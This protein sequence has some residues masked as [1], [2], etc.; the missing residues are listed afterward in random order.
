MTSALING[1]AYSDDGTSGRDMTNGGHRSWLLPMLSDAMSECAGAASAASAASAA[2]ASALSAAAGW[3]GASDGTATVGSGSV[4]LTIEPGRQFRIGTP[5]L[6]YVTAVPGIRMAGIVSAY[7]IVTGALSVDVQVSEGTGTHA[8]WTVVVTGLRGEDGPIGGVE[9]L[10]K[11]AAYTMMAGDRG[12]VVRCS[13]SWALSFQ[14]AAALG[15]GWWAH[16]VNDGTGPIVLDPAGSELIDGDATLSV[17][18]GSYAMVGCDGTGLTVLLSGMHGVRPLPIF[19]AAAAGVEPFTNGE[20][21]YSGLGVTGMTSFAVFAAGTSLVI[22]ADTN[23]ARNTVASSADGLTWIY[24]MMPSVEQWAVVPVGSGFLGVSRSSVKTAWSTDGVSWS[25]R[26]DLAGVPS[27]LDTSG[28]QIAAVG[29]VALLCRSG[30]TGARTANGGVSWAD[31]TL[32]VSVP[33]LMSCGGLFVAH[34]PGSGAYY[35]S[36]TG[37]TG[38]WTVHTLPG[39]TTH[40]TCLP[41]GSVYAW[42][43]SNGSVA[44]YVSD[45]ALIWVATGFEGPALRVGPTWMSI[46]VGY[47]ATRT[48]HAGKWAVRTLHKTLPT[49][50]PG[51]RRFAQLGNRVLILDDAGAC[52]VLD[53]DDGAVSAV[54]RG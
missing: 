22:A 27:A 1:H 11:T 47:G 34:A 26:A 51:A 52:V 42:A 40:C 25:A 53:P 44:S 35:T 21:V 19:S 8:G 31:V 39:G 5:V 23:V 2:A 16:V 3:S 4:A 24:R 20:T 36:A 17:L 9:A 48:R 30:T 29:G 6:M 41:D 28:G 37:A 38:S 7:N 45:D 12:A 32:P 33:M 15:N 14:S 50:Y 43:Y 18:P 13:G 10:S 49:F 54:F 46:G